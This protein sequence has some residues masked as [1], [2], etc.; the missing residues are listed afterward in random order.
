LEKRINSRNLTEIVLFHGEGAKRSH[1]KLFSLEEDCY[2]AARHSITESILLS[3]EDVV[4][5]HIVTGWLDMLKVALWTSGKPSS[6][7]ALALIG[8]ICKL[9]EGLNAPKTGDV[10]DIFRRLYHGGRLDVFRKVCRTAKSMTESKILGRK[11]LVHCHLVG[12]ERAGIVA[13]SL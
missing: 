10:N 4:K 8:K 6:S 1:Q 12:D 5:M 13:S 2:F 9:P 7:D 3:V 11:L